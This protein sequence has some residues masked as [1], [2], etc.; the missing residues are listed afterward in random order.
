MMQTHSIPIVDA[1]P[2]YDNTSPISDAVP[3]NPINDFTNNNNNNKN[4]NIFIKNTFSILLLQLSI[5]FTGC[6]LSI[7]NKP[8]IIEFINHYN[9]VIFIPMITMTFSLIFLMC[10]SKN[11]SVKY[12]MF[13]IFTLSSTGILSIVTIRYNTYIVLQAITSTCVITGCI[14]IY[15]YTCAKR[16]ISF[17][18]WEPYL[19]M[20]VIALIISG[21]FQIFIMSRILNT[22]IGLIGTVVFSGYLLYDV[23]QLYLNE[24]KYSDDPIICAINIY[25]D[26]INIFMYIIQC[27][28]CGNRD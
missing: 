15:A 10:C 18:E 20:L 19:F 4:K 11:K 6:A 26:I 27:L 22:I 13:T 24:D 5:T 7:Y 25:L 23:N 12:V 28:E 14:S 21:I 1:Y 3:L 16:G 9:G 17:G 2:I 8:V